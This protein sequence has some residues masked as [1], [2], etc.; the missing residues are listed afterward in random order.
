MLL[1]RVHKDSGGAAHTTVD[2]R[3]LVPETTWE[4]LQTSGGRTPD[5]WKLPYVLSRIPTLLFSF[6]PQSRLGGERR[7]FVLTPYVPSYVKLWVSILCRN[8][9]HVVEGE[10]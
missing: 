2:G 9:C 3:D 7:S 5:F 8:T 6:G 10:H 4:V 1:E